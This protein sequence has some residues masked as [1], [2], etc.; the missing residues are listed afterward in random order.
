M[1]LVAIAS[2][3]PAPLLPAAPKPAERSDSAP[4]RPSAA[5]APADP[6]RYIS[7]YRVSGAQLLSSLEIGEAVYPFLGPGRTDADIEG[8]RVALEKAYRGKGYETVS[9]SLPPQQIRNGI[10]DFLVTEARIGRVRVNGARYFLPSQI[11]RSAPSLKP[12]TVPNFTDVQR[13]I[14][15]LNTW[16]DRRVTPVLKAGAVPGTVDID[17]NVE[18]KRPLHGSVELNNRQSPNTHDLRLNASLSYGNLWNL[19]HSVGASVQLSPEDPEQVKVFSGFYLARFAQRPDFSLLFQSTKQDSNVSTLGGAAV[20]GRG[21]ILGVR[22]IFT[23]PPGDGFVHSLNFGLDY[24]HYRQALTVGSTQTTTP[25]TY[26][27]VTAGYSATWVRKQSQTELNAS[28]TFGMRGGGSDDAEFGD[29][30]YKARASFFY[31][32]GDLAHTQELSGGAQLYGKIQGQASSQPLVSNEQFAGG[33]LGTARGYLE[34]EALG[35]DAVFGTIELRSPSLLGWTKRKNTEWRVYA[36]A[37]GGILTLQQPLAEQQHRFE[38]ASVGVGTRVQ[39][40]EHFHGSLDVGFPLTTQQ[41]TQ[42][43]EPRFTF[44]L[45]SEF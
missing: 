19:G 43:G 13:D 18:D 36:F 16:P 15:A 33:G 8:A 29:N 9:V 28:A 12:G 30:R 7:E 10:V 22:G 34:A 1:L 6:A 20:A 3:S 11:K 42:S 45:W 2:L 24:K 39:L 44:R 21:D 32:R 35:D 25:I 31:L 38:L 5:A 17:L 40:F 27:P 14:A 23:L 26:F 41:N 4:A 37:E